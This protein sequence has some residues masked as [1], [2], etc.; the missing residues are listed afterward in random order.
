MAALKLAHAQ[1][2]EEERLDYNERMRKKY[3]LSMRQTEL[4]LYNSGTK[5]NVVLAGES[6]AGKSS[7]INGI[8]GLRNRN[9]HGYAAESSV[10]SKRTSRPAAYHC[11]SNAKSFSTITTD[12]ILQLLLYFFYRIS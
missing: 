4:G 1:H 2:L 6:G 9:D 11:E 5:T 8:R 3:S 12:Q 10:Q 7:L